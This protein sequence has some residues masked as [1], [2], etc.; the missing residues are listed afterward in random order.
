MSATIAQ[1]ETYRTITVYD[2]D[3]DE[4][5]D[6]D[7]MARAV[8]QLDGP[9]SWTFVDCERVNYNRVKVRFQRL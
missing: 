7:A 6:V 3:A 9:R 1:D 5:S 4:L 8:E 2:P